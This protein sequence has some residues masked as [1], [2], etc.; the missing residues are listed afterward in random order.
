M[1]N[2]VVIPAEPEPISID[3]GRTAVVVVDM[4]NS[5]CKKGG[6][7]DYVGKLDVR[8]AEQVTMACRAVVRTARRNEMTVVY[9]RMT[10]GLPAVFARHP[11]IDLN[12]LINAIGQILN[13]P[14]SSLRGHLGQTEA[15]SSRLHLIPL[16]VSIQAD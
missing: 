16:T 2:V 14:D 5:F 4:Q 7:M 13:T 9:L 15:R 6:M 3:I 10:Y 12:G 8:Q 11:M 1:A